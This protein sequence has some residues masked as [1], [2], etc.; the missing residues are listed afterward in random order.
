M[1]TPRLLL[2]ATASPPLDL[3]LE[4]AIHLGLEAGLSPPTWRLWET[5]APAVILGVGQ[6]AAREVVLGDS[7]SSAPPASSGN[8]PVLRRHSGGGAVVIGP[9]VI[10]YS[11]FYLMRDLPGAETIRGAMAAALRP[12]RAALARLNVA[13]RPA[14]LSDLAVIAPDGS[15]RKL[16][17]HA[18]ARKRVSLVVH[19]TLLADPDWRL[20]ET[21][22]RFPSRPA[23]YRTGRDHRAFLIS[24]K[25]LGAPCTLAAFAE[26]LA[27]ELGPR[28]RREQ[29]PRAHE[30]ARAGELLAEKYSRKEW[31]LRR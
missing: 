28:W 21:L 8:V 19:G 27:E 4:E 31:T 2:H 3:A 7:P 11:G 22:L 18:Q 14:G 13:A 10:A 15:L 9:G 23:G 24:L 6:E 16:A 30:A 17:G 5:R 29:Q 25:E 12:V 1:D 26:A 20:I